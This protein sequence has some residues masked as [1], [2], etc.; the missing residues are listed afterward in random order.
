MR[1]MREPNCHSLGKDSVAVVD[2]VRFVGT[3]GQ[4][5]GASRVGC[6]MEHPANPSTGKH[7][8]LYVAQGGISTLDN[9]DAEVDV[10]RRK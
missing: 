6:I 2:G 7:R 5:A 9:E 10:A 3:I 4:V 1:T 8:D